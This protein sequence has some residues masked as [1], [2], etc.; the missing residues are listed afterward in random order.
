MQ[1]FYVDS[2]VGNLICVYL[3]IIMRCV[4]LCACTRVCISDFV[5]VCACVCGSVCMFVYFN[6]KKEKK[7]MYVFMIIYI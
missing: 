3:Q 5:P 2:F 7:Y 6:K 1:C 4:V